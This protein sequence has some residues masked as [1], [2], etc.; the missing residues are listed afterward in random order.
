MY[1]QNMCFC[2]FRKSSI[3][4]IFCKLY[5]IRA[6][7]CLWQ[8][9]LYTFVKYK[10]AFNSFYV[11]LH[12]LMQNRLFIPRHIQ[13][14]FVSYKVLNGFN[15]KI[16]IRKENQRNKKKLCGFITCSVKWVNIIF[17][18]CHFSI[19]FFWWYDDRHDDFL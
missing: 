16:I 14:S 18:S 6:N 12:I 9:F 7:F 19:F 8:I 2:I 11:I 1:Y 13:S 17:N 4:F 3:K 5:H 15:D 10:Y